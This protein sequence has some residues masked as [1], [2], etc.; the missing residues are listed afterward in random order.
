SLLLL[1]R[2]ITVVSSAN[3]TMVLEPCTAVQSWVKREWRRGLSTQPCGTPVFRMRV[4][5]V[6]FSTLTDWGLLDRKSSIQLQREVLIPRSLSFVISLEGM[7]VLKAE[8]KSMNSIL[9]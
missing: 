6:W 8:L 3:F 1:M 4:E 7:T 2:P 9:T 5:E